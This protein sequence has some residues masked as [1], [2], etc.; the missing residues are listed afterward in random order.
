MRKTDFINP[1][2]IPGKWY[3]ANFHTH[4][5]TS[6]G[7]LSPLEQVNR[8]AQ[9]G[10]R[11][12]NLS[13]HRRTNN[14]SEFA[15]REDILIVGGMEC[16]PE[17]PGSQ[18]YHIVAVNVPP[19]FEY[20]QNAT[21]C[22]A[23]IRR[24]GGEAIIA[25]PYWNEHNLNEMLKV[26][27][28]IAL[29]VYNS[30]CDYSG[31]P[32]SDSEW[33]QCLKNELYFGGV[34]ADDCHWRDYGGDRSLCDFAKGWTWMKMEKLTVEALLNA[35]R[36]GAYYA[37]CGPEIKKFKIE[38]NQ[39]KLRCSE[40]EKVN[41]MANGFGQ[42]YRIWAPENEGITEAEVSLDTR[43]IKNWPFVRCFVTDK[44]GRKAWTNPIFL[45]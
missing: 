1:F 12:L 18:P 6:D 17:C 10:Y 40:V 45:N 43:N 21:E 30:S 31:R 27:N 35:L 39:V 29:E 13:D 24:A 23:D 11:I 22:V 36:T 4:T 28:S 37:S 20:S 42:G 34:A 9:A 25:H 26:K 15:Q 19:S 5:T 3:K 7:D 8:Y 44:F 14:V 38:D 2:E 33:A 41:L 16:H 32:C